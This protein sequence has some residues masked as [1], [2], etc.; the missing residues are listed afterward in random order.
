VAPKVEEFD[1]NSWIEGL[2][3]LIVAENLPEKLSE[4]SCIN[5][6]FYRLDELIFCISNSA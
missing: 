6:E 5:F 4:E 1:E 3:E 2:P